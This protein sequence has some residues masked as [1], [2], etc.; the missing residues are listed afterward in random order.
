[1]AVAEFTRALQ[2]TDE[3][4]LVVIGRRS[5]RKTSRPVWF[6]HEADAL[7][8]L[9]V[10]G[11]DSEWFKNAQKNPSVTLV[12]GGVEWTARATTI[13]DPAKVRQIA[14]RFRDKYRAE[15]VAKYYSKFDVAVRVPL[16]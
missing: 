3:L 10:K 8:L 13:T 1:M 6:V 9:P 14:D 15:E 5:G 2:A 11:S 12:A 16:A 4:E 7:H